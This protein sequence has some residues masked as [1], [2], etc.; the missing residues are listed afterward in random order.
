M[1]LVELVREKA[2]DVEVEAAIFTTPARR[3]ST[4]ELALSSSMLRR[5]KPRGR[6]AP[7]DHVGVAGMDLKRARCGDLNVTGSSNRVYKKLGL[8]GGKESVVPEI[9]WS[10]TGV[11]GLAVETDP[12]SLAPT[13]A[14]Y[15]PNR[16][17]LPLQHGALLDMQL[18]VAG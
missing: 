8:R 3:R 16:C 13:N 17:T 14:A 9:H 18:D 5:S 12:A 15:D 2:L 10:R 1:A 11:A 6:S 4:A 7:S